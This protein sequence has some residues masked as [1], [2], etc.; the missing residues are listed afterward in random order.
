MKRKIVSTSAAFALALSM[1]AAG[2]AVS[3]EAVPGV[4]DTQIVI[5]LHMPLS[6]PQEAFGSDTIY[7]ANMWYDQ[8]NKNGGIHGRKIRT[9]LEDDK[10]NATEVVS[11]V[12]KLVTVDNVFMINGG[13]CGATIL[14][15]REFVAREKIP[16]VMISAS[17]DAVL[18]P[19]PDRYMFGSF[20]ASQ[21]THGATLVDFAVNYARAKSVAYIS[22]DDEQAQVGFAGA[23]AKAGELGITIS[24]YQPIAM[25]ATDVT[26]PL[27]NVLATQPDAIVLNHYVG[28]APLIVR[29]AY[30]VGLTVPIIAV[31]SAAPDLQAFAKAVGNPAALA[32]FYINSPLNDLASGPL[33]ER[34]VEMYKD[35]Y[36]EKEPNNIMA[37][38]LPSAIVI[39]KALEAVGRD[40]TREKM[41]EALEA[42]NFD[43]EVLA[44]PVQFSK[45]R[46]DA[47]RSTIF[48]KFDGTNAERV[49]GIFTAD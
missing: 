39:T 33:Q 13:A 42:T 48:F 34:W 26:A 16:Y 7:A 20:A 37:Y 10:C 3:Q 30:E 17:G 29:K 45:T 27:L 1:L 12:K 44:A 40:L 2:P 36:P 28:I 8:I 32:N 47:L 19:E 18:Y 31:T 41:I 11:V 21:R 9:V 46:H 25:T 23:Q 49:P 6:G 24:S 4:T 5:G 15:A 14:A 22:P 43:T 38:G 35:Y